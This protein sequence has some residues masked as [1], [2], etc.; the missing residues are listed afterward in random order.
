MPGAVKVWAKYPR[1]WMGLA[2]PD[3]ETSWAM[4]PSSNS[5]VTV[6]PART[7]RS[8]GLKAMLRMLTMTDVFAG[9]SATVDAGA[10]PEHPASRAQA[11]IMAPARPA[12]T[13]HMPTMV[14]P[15]RGL[16]PV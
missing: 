2:N 15:A 16:V 11:V 3:P 4:V 1:D 6:W 10:P 14:T 5:Q 9:G 8:G 7:V 12:R 13:P